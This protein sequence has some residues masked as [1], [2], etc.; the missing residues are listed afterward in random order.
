[1]GKKRGVSGRDEACPGGGG[2]GAGGAYIG[3]HRQ[4]KTNQNDTHAAN[5][6]KYL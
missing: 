5:H 1:M 3:A 2:G 4:E 6:K